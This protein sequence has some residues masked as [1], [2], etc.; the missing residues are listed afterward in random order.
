MQLSIDQ[1]STDEYLALL[2]T[3][4]DSQQAQFYID[5]SFLMWLT[6]I[7]KASRGEFFDWVTRIGSNRFH[8]PDWAAHEYYGHFVERTTATNIEKAAKALQQALDS[9]YRAL[10]PALCEVPQGAGA[11]SASLRAQHRS[12][13]EK[14]R[15]VSNDVS[16]WAK[17]SFDD[18]AREVTKFISDH[19]ISKTRIFK[20]LESIHRSLVTRYSGRVPPGFQDSQKMDTEER[21]GNKAGDLLF[22]RE[23]LDHAR[24]QNRFCSHARYTVIISRDGKNDWQAKRQVEPSSSSAEKARPKPSTPIEKA[25]RNLHSRQDLRIPPAAHPTLIHEATSFGK[26]EKLILLDEIFLGAHFMRRKINQEFA[27]AAVV[28]PLLD[29]GQTVDS[30]FDVVRTTTAASTNTSPTTGNVAH[31]SGTPVPTAPASTPAAAGPSGASMPTP[32]IVAEVL[33]AVNPADVAASRTYLSNKLANAAV[34]ARLVDILAIDDLNKMEPGRA[35]STALAIY[36]FGADGSR[37]SLLVDIINI[38]PR[39]AGTVS[40]YM[41]G[42]LLSSIYYETGLVLRTKPDAQFV[43]LLFDLRGQPFAEPVL[44]AVHKAL[45]SDGIKVPYS[46]IRGDETIEVR[47]TLKGKSLDALYVGGTN[48]HTKVCATDHLLFTNIFNSNSATAEEIIARMAML[49]LIPKSAFAM[50]PNA[51]KSNISFRQTDGFEQFYQLL[52]IGG[53]NV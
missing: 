48:L 51:V 46:P 31:P 1:L 9:S 5:T 16:R 20:H 40:V 39:L 30:Y 26:V 12:A 25:E 19:S 41:Y 2:Q 35:A 37:P 34:D 52:P 22:W 18:N 47:F 53:P 11:T 43:D 10:T 50:P 21:G 44:E 14:L 28:P 38:L 27:A 24:S 49:Y 7:S 3:A 15:A 23:V 45:D 42:A 36:S 32:Y 13:F 6:N 4:L 29:D 8:V 33:S 17:V